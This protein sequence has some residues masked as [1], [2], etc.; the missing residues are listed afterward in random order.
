MFFHVIYIIINCKFS[1]YCPLLYLLPRLL[2]LVHRQL[3]GRMRSSAGDWQWKYRHQ[4][5]FMIIL[6]S[7]SLFAT[8][9]LSSLSSL[10]INSSPT[11]TSLSR[12]FTPASLFYLCLL[13]S[14]HE[15]CYHSSNP[16]S[17]HDCSIQKSSTNQSI[18]SFPF[19]SSTT[20]RNILQKH[21]YCQVGF[22]RM[23]HIANIQQSQQD[24]CL[25]RGYTDRFT[26]YNQW[27]GIVFI[28]LFSSILALLLTLI[29]LFSRYSTTINSFFN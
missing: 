11:S 14:Q 9:T 24:K 15:L 19:Y 21:P 28:S 5:L 16:T 22:S 20:T 26:L 4:I 2:V 12:N 29:S 23:G 3:R 8:C 10:A 1:L 7:T 13:Y 17:C 27:K 6:I 18:L 25:T